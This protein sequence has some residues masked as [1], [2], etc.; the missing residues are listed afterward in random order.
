MRS[1]TVSSEEVVLERQR[2]SYSRGRLRFSW[3]SK[4]VRL[5]VPVLALGLFLGIWETS[6][7]SEE[8]V[9]NDARRRG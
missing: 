7:I 8:K 9:G 4:E 2:Q 3:A 6:C 1:R 5:E